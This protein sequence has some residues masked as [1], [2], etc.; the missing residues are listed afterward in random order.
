MIFVSK[1]FSLKSL[2][3]DV[4]LLDKTGRFLSVNRMSFNALQVVSNA[5]I[6]ATVL[7]VCQAIH[8]L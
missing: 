7:S 1:H 8:S 5:I 2:N 4:Y 6:I 3:R